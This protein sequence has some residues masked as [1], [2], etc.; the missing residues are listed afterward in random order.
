VGGP[1]TFGGLASGLDSNSIIDKLIQLDSQPLNTLQ[2]ELAAVQATQ[3]S[4]GTVGGKLST[5]GTALSALSTPD[6]FLVR[7]ATSS[8]ES[9][10]TAAAGAGPRGAA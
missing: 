4:V 6:S 9:V 2:S 8:D 5:L 10:L 7:D 1:I 3:T